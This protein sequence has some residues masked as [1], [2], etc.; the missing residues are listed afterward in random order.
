VTANTSEDVEKEE[1]FSIDCGIII[2]QN[3]SGNDFGNSS[4]N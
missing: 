3:H 1:H 4:E 2:Q